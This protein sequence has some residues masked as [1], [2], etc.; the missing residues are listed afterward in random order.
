MLIFFVGSSII[1]SLCL[2]SYAFGYRRG[3]N[4]RKIGQVQISGDKSVQ[5]AVV[6]NKKKDSYIE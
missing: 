1:C 6:N 5:I 3:L 4:N 2:I